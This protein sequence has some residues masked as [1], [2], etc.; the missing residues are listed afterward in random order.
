MKYLDERL[1]VKLR[2]YIHFHQVFPFFEVHVVCNSWKSMQLL[3]YI[4]FKQSVWVNVNPKQLFLF[5][6][7]QDVN[8]TY[9]RFSKDVQDI[10]WTS[11]VRSIYVLCPGD[12]TVMHNMTFNVTSDGIAQC[13]YN[14]GKNNR[15]S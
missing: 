5:F 8:W 4:T 13:T 11:S 9:I 7:T 12:F 1:I 14:R 2:C 6:W 3:R 15:T 10:F